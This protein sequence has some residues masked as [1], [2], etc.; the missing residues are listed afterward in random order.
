MAFLITFILSNLISLLKNTIQIYLTERIK[1][2]S[3]TDLLNKFF[4]SN[5]NSIRNLQKSEIDKIINSVTEKFSTFSSS[6]FN[7]IE[8]VIYIFFIS[9]IIVFVNKFVII[10]LILL[11]LLFLL[12]YLIFDSLNKKFYVEELEIKKK[13]LF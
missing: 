1:I 5:L 2:F 8:A 11:I 3:S 7:F 6:I 10:G 13:L 12:F 9:V 4:K